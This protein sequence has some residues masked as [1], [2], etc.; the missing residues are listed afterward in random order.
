MYT[1][2]FEI[3]QYGGSCFDPLFYYYPT[4]A[5]TFDQVEHTFMV[6]GALKVSPILNANVTY[7]FSSYFPAGRWVDLSDYSVVDSG[8]TGQ[9][10]TL[11]TSNTVKVHQRPGTIITK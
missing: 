1:C 7:N 2:L 5:N 4:D 6:S 8:A 9:W 3:N 11:N 10:V